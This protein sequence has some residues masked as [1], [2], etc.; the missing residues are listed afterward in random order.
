MLNLRAS[1]LVRDPFGFLQGR[2]SVYK[3][4]VLRYIAYSA[5]RDPELSLREIEAQNSI[6]LSRTL[7]TPNILSKGVL[8]Q[9]AISIPS[10][11]FPPSHHHRPFSDKFPDKMLIEEVTDSH[12]ATSNVNDTSSLDR[13]RP[14]DSVTPHSNGTL[15]TPSWTWR[16]EGGEIRISIRVPKL[17]GI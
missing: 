11:L 4:I 17:V 8:G 9:R 1:W 6:S 5:H 15:E 10:I 12:A 3:F 16:Q 14:R 13:V 2:S 7:G